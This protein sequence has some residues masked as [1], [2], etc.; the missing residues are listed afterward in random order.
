[1]NSMIGGR[2]PISLPFGRGV[3]LS[4]HV[5]SGNSYTYDVAPCHFSYVSS[6]T[7]SLECSP[8]RI[9]L[10]KVTLLLWLTALRLSVTA[11]F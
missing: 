11:V 9:A 6:Q 7:C 3:D 2:A 5:L 1:M 10:F 4:P 8:S